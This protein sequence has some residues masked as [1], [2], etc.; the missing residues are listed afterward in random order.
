MQGND[1]KVEHRMPQK[2][3]DK[4]VAYIIAIGLHIDGFTVAHEVIGQDLKYA[5][6]CEQGRERGV[7]M[8]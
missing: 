1:D 8:M 7:R 4:I 5:H 3:K 2:M 6:G